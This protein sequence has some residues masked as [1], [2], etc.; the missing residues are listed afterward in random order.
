MSGLPRLLLLLQFTVPMGIALQ[1]RFRKS[2]AIV[3][4]SLIALTVAGLA[5]VGGDSR[6]TKL[7]L[8]SGLFSG[9]VS[10]F[11][12]WMGRKGTEAGQEARQKALMLGIHVDE[13]TRDLPYFSSR[14]K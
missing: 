4:G 1:T 10:W 2:P 7:F 6:Q 14:N 13:V 5:A 12:V 11:F 3:F 8:A 9:L